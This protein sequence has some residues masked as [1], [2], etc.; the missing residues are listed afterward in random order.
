MKKSTK[1]FWWGVSAVAVGFLTY[2]LLKETMS[3]SSKEEKEAMHRKEFIER[4]RAAMKK[5]EAAVKEA[6]AM[7]ATHKEESDILSSDKVTH[8]PV[9]I[10]EPAEKKV[11]EDADK[12][13]DSLDISKASTQELD[14]PTEHDL[15]HTTEIDEKQT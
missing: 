13:T 1:N 5:K 3:V 8:D 9:E 15:E 6:V 14:D 7:T 4:H 12:A 11:N 2:S 10:T